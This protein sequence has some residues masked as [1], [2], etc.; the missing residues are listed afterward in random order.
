VLRSLR[1]HSDSPSRMV[2][3][4][5]MSVRNSVDPTHS[6]NSSAPLFWITVWGSM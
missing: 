1:Y 4:Y 6:R 2:C 5:G 3:E